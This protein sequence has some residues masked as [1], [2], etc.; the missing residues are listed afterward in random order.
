MEK[1]VIF[2]LTL[3]YYTGKKKLVLP[4][5]LEPNVRVILKR[6]NLELLVLALIE[7]TTHG[8][9]LTDYKCEI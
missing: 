5:Q 9:G 6:P 4:S 7:A 1:S 8:T 3:I 2:P